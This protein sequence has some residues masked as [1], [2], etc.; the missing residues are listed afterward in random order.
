MAGN[1]WHGEKTIHES[2]AVFEFL[3]NSM[4]SQIAEMLLNPPS[5]ADPPNLRNP[6]ISVNSTDLTDLLGGWLVGGG[7]AAPPKTGRFIVKIGSGREAPKVWGV[8]SENPFSGPKSIF[9]QNYI[10]RGKDL[11]VGMA[12]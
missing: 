9:V 10:F 7:G 4:D 2:P 3:M 8:F 5:P 11:F 6:V 1:V 12:K